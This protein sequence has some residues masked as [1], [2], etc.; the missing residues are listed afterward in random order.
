[1]HANMPPRTSTRPRRVMASG[2]ALLAMAMLASG[3]GLLDGNDGEIETLRSELASLREEV[4]DLS[5]D[6]AAMAA[7]PA[8]T[9]APVETTT[10]TEA[11]AEV[12]T[13]TMAAPDEPDEPVVD[14]AAILT[15]AYEWGPSDATVALQEVLG[16]T[17]D[18]WYGPGTRAA[19]LAELDARGLS[20]DNVPSAPATTTTTEAVEEGE[21]EGEGDGG[22][23]AE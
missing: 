14:E 11:P 1:M 19:H 22:E 20:T 8:T 16:I 6:V 12:T 2:S 15:A 5:A 9:A 3:C 7:V 21:G 13:T 4:V 10:T 23:S 18:G 17:A